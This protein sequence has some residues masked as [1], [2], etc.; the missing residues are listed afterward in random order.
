MQYAGARARQAEPPRNGS[1]MRPPSASDLEWMDS[2]PPPDGV[3]PQGARRLGQQ[4]TSLRQVS[5]FAPPSDDGLPPPDLPPPPSDDPPP[6]EDP[7]PA[8]AAHRRSV[9]PPR[10]P[11]SDDDFD[12]TPP[13]LPSRAAISSMRAAAFTQT[14][15]PPPEEG[16]PQAAPESSPPQRASARS[17]P[18]GSQGWEVLSTEQLSVLLDRFGVSC[19]SDSSKGHLATCLHGFL[20]AKPGEQQAGAPPDDPAAF[21]PPPAAP[22]PGDGV[23]SPLLLSTSALWTIRRNLARAF[24]ISLG[25]VLPVALGWSLLGDSAHFRGT[26]VSYSLAHPGAQLNTS[27]PDLQRW[28][29]E[30]P[31]SMITSSCTAN[32]SDT[33]V[34]PDNSTLSMWRSR[35][36]QHVPFGCGFW[37][38]FEE[39]H[40]AIVGSFLLFWHLFWMW[41]RLMRT[42]RFD[43]AIEQRV[44]TVTKCRCCGD[45][46]TGPKAA[47]FLE[48]RS[49]ARSITRGHLHS[50]C[51]HQ[52]LNIWFLLQTAAMA[53][54]G[55]FFVVQ[56]SRLES[57]GAGGTIPHTGSH[58][59]FAFAWGFIVAGGLIGALFGTK[60]AEKNYLS[61]VPGGKAMQIIAFTVGV[62]C[63]A[64]I[65]CVAGQRA[66][67]Y[68]PVVELANAPRP[69]EQHDDEFTDDS[70]FAVQL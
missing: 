32:E 62:G 31:V 67:E 36:R 15:R 10:G 21:F 68:T 60:L 7:P 17:A 28:S 39:N 51:A 30:T 40:V 43:Q 4:P 6:P 58:T 27:R 16:P 1:R 48:Q 33:W 26:S 3:Q 13:P 34:A 35:V 5:L 42:Q 69:R 53:A 29:T 63:A 52:L 20:S 2:P 38:I 25:I 37:E 54:V 66:L 19:P 8:V 22:P 49:A 18:T 59:F 65:V 41:F 23:G 44:K 46:P 24:G 50:C 45:K 11:P 57:A 55:I 61:G 47:D 14:L 12:R 56:T 70:Y 64:G 9:T